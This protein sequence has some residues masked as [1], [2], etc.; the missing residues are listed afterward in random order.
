[1]SSPSRNQKSNLSITT[2][3]IYKSLDDQTALVQLPEARTKLDNETRKRRDEELIF[4]SKNPVCTINKLSK[5]SGDLA[6]LRPEEL[7]AVLHD[8]F[9]NASVMKES[10]CVAESI[11]YGDSHNTGLSKNVKIRHWIKDLHQIG[12]ESVAGYALLAGVGDATDVFV[13]KVPRDSADDDL[14]H[15]LFVGLYGTNPLRALVP[16]F[17]YIFG[18]FRCSPP[19]IG[20]KGE[21]I[22]IYCNED[23]GAQNVNYVLYEK[24]FPNV[25][26]KEYVQTCTG[27]DFINKYLQVLY[28]LRTGYK[29][30]EF[31]HY[32][33]HSE[34][35]I[36]WD[37]LNGMTAIPY[38]TEQ[39]SEYLITDK[40][41]TIID[42]GNAF[43]RYKGKPY[44]VF[45]LPHYGVSGLNGF[46]MHDAYKLLGF[47]M[48]DMLEAKNMECFNMASRIMRFFNKT[49]DLTTLIQQQRQTLYFLPSNSAFKNVTYDDLIKYIRAQPDLNTSFVIADP[50]N[51]P[52][53]Q[54][55]YDGV[56]L[57]SQGAVK[58]IGLEENKVPDN[59][60][61]FYDRSMY[62]S[63]DQKTT[64]FNNLQKAFLVNYESSKNKILDQIM[65]NVNIVN[66]Y[67]PK[68]IAPYIGDYKDALK[69]ETLNLFK[70]F[71][72][73]TMKVFEAFYELRIDEQLF[74]NVV[75][76]YETP[77]Q[78][79][80]LP[81]KTSKI[82]QAY[83]QCLE[84][85]PYLSEASKTISNL[86]AMLYSNDL[87]QRQ[88]IMNAVQKNPGYNWYFKDLVNA[89]AIL[90]AQ[91]Y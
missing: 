59:F 72:K 16:N 61:D 40:I 80:T 32:D 24:I 35:V 46:P 77:E 69:P 64:D 52:I 38:E 33:L 34:N 39:G 89:G 87:Q 56:C 43:I 86:I 42:Y 45:G 36:I 28:G 15:E 2:N 83:N 7:K 9:Y 5:D 18:G 4:I 6:N 19:I 63:K 21:K 70:N 85:Y 27:I 25:S 8:N 47:C 65:E 67:A 1:M 13:V 44:G 55:G 26:M 73:D 29:N 88:V 76:L 17:S 53:L 37:I 23:L 3:E 57:T 14:Q 78:Q 60:Y 48:A 74:T 58:E 75:A 81:E 22:D 54:C 11:F 41:S 84:L 71:V 91:I 51:T 90:K 82:F 62:L 20:V 12:A 68:L 79:T 30:C 66:L 31:T 50:L 10:L 49:E